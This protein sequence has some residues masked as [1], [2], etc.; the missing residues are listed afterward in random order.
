MGLPEAIICDLDSTLCDISNRAKYADAGDWDKFHEDVTKDTPN[1]WCVKILDAMQQ[2]NP[3]L[4]VLFVTARPEELRAQTS[5][6]LQKNLPIYVFANSDL[7]MKP[8]DHETR[9]ATEYKRHVYQDS[10][11]DNYNVLFALEDANSVVAMYRAEGLTVL[12][13]ADNH[14]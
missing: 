2:V 8:D 7:Y 3:S 4:Q 12:Q 11:K 1:D 10:I 5:A 9:N 6:W 14:W 13:P